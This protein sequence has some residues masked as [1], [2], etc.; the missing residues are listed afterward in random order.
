[1]NNGE[2]TMTTKLLQAEGED[3]FSPISK[4]ST[5][6]S[7]AKVLISEK[8]IKKNDKQTSKEIL[9]EDEKCFCRGYN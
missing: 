1:V 2:K 7:S 6:T 5:D 4:F 8:S 9:D 3:D